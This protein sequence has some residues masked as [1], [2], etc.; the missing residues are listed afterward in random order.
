MNDYLGSG[1]LMEIREKLGKLLPHWIEHNDAHSESYNEW[2]A[3][4]RQAGMTQ[5]AT[6]IEEAVA[7]V[8]EANKALK[9]AIAALDG[10]I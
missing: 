5:V 1:V 10:D 7:R 3:Q 4:A 9:Q 6:G 8:E 2:A